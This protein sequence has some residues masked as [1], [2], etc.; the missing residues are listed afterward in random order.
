MNKLILIIYKTFYYKVETLC[1]LSPISIY[2][3]PASRPFPTQKPTLFTL[4]GQSLPP[5]FPHISLPQMQYSF[6][7]GKTTW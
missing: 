7:Q 3:W 1:K 5:L 2:I 4:C 6:I